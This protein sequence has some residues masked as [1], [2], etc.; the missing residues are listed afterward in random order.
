MST[1]NL[2]KLS[3]T[4]ENSILYR[5]RQNARVLVHEA[6]LLVPMY[7]ARMWGHL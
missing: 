1:L 3:K 2:A 7:R 6:P 5:P 4:V